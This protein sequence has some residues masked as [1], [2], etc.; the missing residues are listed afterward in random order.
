[1]N[2]IGKADCPGNGGFIKS[3][4]TSSEVTAMPK[5]NSP[6]PAKPTLAERLAARLTVTREEAADALTF[7]V[8]TIDRLISSKKLKASKI[9]RRV[10]IKVPSLIA[11]VDAAEL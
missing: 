7:D 3:R 2:G 9:G 8:Q 1:L 5:T 10:V 11:M 4:R 6:V